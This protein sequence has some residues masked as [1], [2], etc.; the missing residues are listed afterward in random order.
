ME[1]YAAAAVTIAREQYRQRLDYESG[2][3]VAFEAVL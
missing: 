2:S 1:A 3:M